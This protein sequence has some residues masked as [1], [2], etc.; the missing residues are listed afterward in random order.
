MSNT[1]FH[2]GNSQF[3]DDEMDSVIGGEEEDSNEDNESA[4]ERREVESRKYKFKETD[5]EV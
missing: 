4:R 2:A 3:E 1:K 5:P